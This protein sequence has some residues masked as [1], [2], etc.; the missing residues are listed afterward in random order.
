MVKFYVERY[1]V[2]RTF[3]FSRIVDEDG[4]E[5]TGYVHY[6]NRSSHDSRLHRQ[7]DYMIREILKE[8]TGKTTGSA[9]VDASSVLKFHKEWYECEWKKKH[10]YR[11]L[12]MNK[13][14]EEGI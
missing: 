5:L 6:R 14:L 7:V 13:W 4:T 9:Y 11:I 2:G 8:A 12:I 10:S 3:C 1:W